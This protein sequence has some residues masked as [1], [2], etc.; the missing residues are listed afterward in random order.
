VAADLFQ[1]HR[2]DRRTSDGQTDMRKAT[3]AYRN[4]AFEL[5]NYKLYLVNYPKIQT[6][7]GNTKAV[8]RR[9]DRC[10]VLIQVC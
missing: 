4:F 3:V 8:G 10:C 7:S 5:K 1:A 9:L 2:Q 6:F